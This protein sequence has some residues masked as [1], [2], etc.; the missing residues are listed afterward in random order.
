M[1]LGITAEEY[2]E[3]TVQNPKKVASVFNNYI[4]INGYLLCFS[5]FI[6]K[7]AEKLIE[8]EQDNIKKSE[9]LSKR[10]QE[11]MAPM[12]EVSELMYVSDMD[13]YN[14]LFVSRGLW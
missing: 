1:I 5:P 6:R 11:L 8:A 10:A 3:H 14:L 7:S 4:W 13:T 12:N 2:T 9:Q